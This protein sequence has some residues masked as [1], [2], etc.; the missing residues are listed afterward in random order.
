MPDIFER[1]FESFGKKTSDYYSLTRLDPSYRVVW[2]DG[3]NE[4]PADVSSLR[5]LFDSWE[6]GAGK[7][8]DTFLRE[9]EFKYRIAMQKLV[10][11]PGLSLLEF[12]DLEIM[13]GIFRMDL[14]SSMK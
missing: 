14:F 12:A 10:F 5:K 1:Y 8:L 13:K 4:V 11:R 3:F 6:P 9:A 7:K 2:A